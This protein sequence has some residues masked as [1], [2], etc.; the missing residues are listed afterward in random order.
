MK[1]VTLPDQLNLNPSISITVFAYESNKEIDKQ[2]VLLNKNTFS[3]LQEGSKE[4]FF[5]NSSYAI[6]N[7]QFLLMKSG[8]C[9]MT[10]KLSND[11]KFY[12]SILLFFSEEEVLKFMRKFKLQAPKAKKFYSTYSINYDDYIQRFVNSLL[13]ISKLSSAIQNNILRTKF[14]EIMLYLIEQNGVDFL[15]S[16]IKNNDNQ[17]QKFIQTV[18][19]NTLNKLTLKE[20]SFLSNMSVSTFKREFE[21]QFHSSPSKWFLDKRLEHAAF[22]LKNKSKRPSD[23]FEEIGYE[24][25]SNFIQAF[26]TKFG[27]TPKQYQST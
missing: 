6:D 27:V 17:T 25:L 7:S 1:T 15:Y 9:L 24:N 14:E 10:E 8:H 16:L 4:V 11:S 5:D 21:K 23:I 18:E 12:K 3:F 2:Q 26:R 22:L 19:S 13:D 20:L